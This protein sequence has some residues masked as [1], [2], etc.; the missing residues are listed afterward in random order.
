MSDDLLADLLAAV[1]QQLVSPQTE[2]VAKTYGRLLKAGLGED[3]AKRQI[4]LCLG[5]QMDE[6]MR[7]KRGFD[8]KS[9][10][11]ALDELPFEDE[12]E[13]EDPETGEN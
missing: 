9:Y 5:E 7:T 12:D 10:R 13:P 1:E 2:Y 4:A 3:A 11:E 6:M 8:E